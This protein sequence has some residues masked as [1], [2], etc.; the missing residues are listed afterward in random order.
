[1]SDHNTIKLEFNNKRTWRKYSNIWRLNN[2]LLHDHW[3]IEE[4]GRKSKSSWNLMR[5]KT[6][7]IKTY[8]TQ[9]RQS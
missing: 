4:T 9:Q 3:V 5:M 8:G 6:Q 1:M 2:T 7:S